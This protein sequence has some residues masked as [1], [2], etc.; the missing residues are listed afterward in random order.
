MLVQDTH[1]LSPK[2]AV[3][4]PFGLLL[5]VVANL[6]KQPLMSIVRECL[7]LHIAALFVLALATFVP[8][9]VLWLPQVM[10]YK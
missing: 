3:T 9:T 5:F 1:D 6:I 2:Q 10:G 7:P 8:E 4:P